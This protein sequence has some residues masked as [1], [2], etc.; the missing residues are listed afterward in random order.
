[1]KETCQKILVFLC[2]LTVGILNVSAASSCDY[3]TQVKL[4]SEA[5]N[6]KTS[7][8]VKEIKTGKQIVSDMGEGMEDEVYTGVEVSIYNLTENLYL[9]VTNLQT[10]ETKTYYYADTN[11]GSITFTRGE[12]GLS[13]IVTYQVTVYS[14]HSDCKDEELKKVNIVTPRYNTFSAE[15]L[16]QNSTKYYCQTYITEELN[17]T[18]ED[19]VKQATAALKDNETKPEDQTEKQ[20]SFFEKYGVYMIA[21]IGVILIGVVT[22]V[23]VRNKQRSS[24]K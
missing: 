15:A 20:E 2:L 16:C 14:N 1:M 22:T 9:K 18:F 21:V 12:E 4:N 24:I 19:F 13:E 8:E 23:I 11:D 5:N 17:M 6:I 7:Y 10:S 3:E